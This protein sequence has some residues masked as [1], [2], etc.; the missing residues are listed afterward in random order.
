[1]AGSRC[2]ASRAQEGRHHSN[3]TTG[4]GAA[5]TRSGPPR[6][7]R[8]G[9]S[10]TASSHAPAELAKACWPVW[11]TPA[12]P[13]CSLLSRRTAQRRKDSGGIPTRGA[14]ARSYDAQHLV[15]FDTASFDGVTSHLVLMDIPDFTPLSRR[16]IASAG[17]RLARVRDGRCLLLGAGRCGSPAFT[18]SLLATDRRPDYRPLSR[19]LNR[20]VGSIGPTAGGLSAAATRPPLALRHLGSDVVSTP[21]HE[22]PSSSVSAI[23]R[24]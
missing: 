23:A 15:A 20:P 9:A 8:S 14:T 19:I 2:P 18:S 3:L 13:I 22:S 4:H 16:S 7:G 10:L 24:E 5:T 11:T 1:M 17:Q 12:F 21:W 6:A